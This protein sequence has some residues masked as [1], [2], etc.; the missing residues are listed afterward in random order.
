MS[1]FD[2][3]PAIEY[4]YG[5]VPGIHENIQ[6]RRP[7]LVG[8]EVIQMILSSMKR[9]IDRII[10]NQW[11]GKEWLLSEAIVDLVQTYTYCSDDDVNEYV[12]KHL[13]T[14]VE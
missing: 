4:L 1:L 11:S 12:S 2:N 9:I 7:S 6:A 5:S 8:W 13:D 3:K 10:L 14:M